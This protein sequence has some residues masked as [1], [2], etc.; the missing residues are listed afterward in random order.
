MYE[1]KLPNKQIFTLNVNNDIGNKIQEML[2]NIFVL[3]KL[4]NY[5]INY[6]YSDENELNINIGYYHPN[7]G[8]KDMF[9]FIWQENNKFDSVG[10]NIFYS[11]LNK[12]N[13]KVCIIKNDIPNLLWEAYNLLKEG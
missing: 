12:T 5:K 8:N 10:Y 11:R 9:L 6:K 2:D 1:I 3:C 7:N 4:L 13:E